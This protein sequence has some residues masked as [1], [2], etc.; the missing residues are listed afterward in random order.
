[1]NG[2]E[3]LEEF[4]GTSSGKLSIKAVVVT[5]ASLL[6]LVTVSLGL[7]WGFEQLLKPV[8]AHKQPVELR[9]SPSRPALAPLDPFQQQQRKAYEEAQ[10]KLLTSYGWI[11]EK[12]KIAH[13]P[14]E[15]AMKEIVEQYG[16]SK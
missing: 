16:K 1:M 5:L 3:A 9:T 2:P 12:Q 11:D 8:L 7:M 15:Q 6:A 13:I 10:R 14:I 4:R